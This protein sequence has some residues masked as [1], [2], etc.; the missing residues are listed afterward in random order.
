MTKKKKAFVTLDVLVEEAIKNYEKFERLL[1][2]GERIKDEDGNIY[3]PEPDEIVRQCFSTRSTARA[4]LPPYWFLTNKGTLI[5]CYG[6]HLRWM[7]LD[8][9][10]NSG[11]TYYHVP[12]G[13]F[14]DRPVVNLSIDTLRN[15]VFGGR[16]FGRANSLLEKYGILA[17]NRWYGKDTLN[18]HHEGGPDDHDPENNV[19]AT[20]S[21]HRMLNAV[22]KAD[23]SPEEFARWA[24]KYAMPILKKEN[25]NKFTVILPGDYLDK[26]GV[27]HIDGKPKIRAVDSISFPAEAIAGFENMVFMPLDL[28][29]KKRKK[30]N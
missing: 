21:V 12:T 15:L 28:T 4:M 18:G 23:A 3:Q 1:A 30:K 2:N 27:P 24:T 13:R 26:D 17:F 14:S 19:I 25:P 20:G 8:P 16:R 7:K 5:S 6:K 11:R 22:P 29:K 9:K 10:D